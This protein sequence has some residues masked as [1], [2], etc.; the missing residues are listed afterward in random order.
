M[1]KRREASSSL[2]SDST[3]SSDSDHSGRRTNATRHRRFYSSSTRT[4]EHTVHHTGTRQSSHG[5]V[6]GEMRTAK[7]VS[8]NE[9]PNGGIQTTANNTAFRLPLKHPAQLAISNRIEDPVDRSAV[10]LSVPSVVVQPIVSPPVVT[11]A[12]VSRA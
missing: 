3:H 4:R 2:S 7:T 12:L 5:L 11:P 9:S 10:K 6:S 8:W 1:A